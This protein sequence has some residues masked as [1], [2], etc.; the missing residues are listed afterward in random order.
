LTTC[1]IEI[2]FGGAAVPGNTISLAGL[3]VADGDVAVVCDDG[4]EAGLAGSCD[5]LDDGSFFNGDDAVVL[6]CGGTTVDAIGQVGVDPGGEWLA[7]GVGTQN[8]TLRRDCAVTT[9][10]ADSGDAFDPSLQWSSEALDDFTDVGQYV[11]PP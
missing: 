2:Y 3:S 5:L 11:C 7:G 10:D 8:E 9:G 4:A 6:V 1:A